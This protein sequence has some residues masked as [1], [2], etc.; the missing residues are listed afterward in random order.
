MATRLKRYGF[1]GAAVGRQP[2]AVS[3]QL[4]E[5]S[6]QHPTFKDREGSTQPRTHT[7]PW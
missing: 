6:V 7:N 3:H 5:K 1:H 2:S 4:L